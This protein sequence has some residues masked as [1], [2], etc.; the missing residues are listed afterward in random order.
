MRSRTAGYAFVSLYFALLVLFGIAPTVYAID[1]AVTTQGGHFTGLSNFINSFND[2]RFIPA[3]ENIGEV[4]AI[5][6][7]S[8][9]VLVV[10]LALMMHSMNRRA[11]SLFRFLFY[12]PGALSG[13]ASVLVWLFMLEPGISPWDAFLHGLNW[14]SLDQVLLPGHLAFIFAIIA[15]W[16][17]A[18]GWIVVMYGALNNIPFDVLEAAKLDGA[19]AWQT[20]WHVKIPLIK[21]WITYM[22]ILAFA[23]G[24]QLFVE[25]QLVGQASLGLVSQYW[26]PNELAYSM[27]FQSDNFNQAA[28]V[29]VDL[30][31]L[32]L[33]CAGILVFRTR[34]FDVE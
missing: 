20:A 29:S 23:T 7:G 33:L 8:L 19:N 32:G 16:T 3:F 10:G 14:T 12:L 1:L 5:W 30:L 6:L 28:A 27:A 25:P 21:R 17:G 15:F 24:T 18:G 2:F 11:S 4:M 9:I 13:A 31:V 22:V 34:L 26:S